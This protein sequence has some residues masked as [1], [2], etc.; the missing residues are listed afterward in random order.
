MKERRLPVVIVWSTH[1]DVI[2][3]AATASLRAA[4]GDPECVT[5]PGNHSW[6]LAEPARFGEVITNVCRAAACGC[7]DTVRAVRDGVEPG[8]LAK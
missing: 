6:L 2:P 1:D 8:G 3:A 5:V 4:V 7:Y